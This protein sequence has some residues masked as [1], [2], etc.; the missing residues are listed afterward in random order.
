MIGQ[1]ASDTWVNGW[2]LLN[3]AVSVLNCNDLPVHPCHC[4]NGLQILP[5]LLL[6]YVHLQSRYIS[7]IHIAAAGAASNFVDEAG[8]IL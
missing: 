2:S 5:C 1:Y 3:A 6:V 7:S 8:N 4:V